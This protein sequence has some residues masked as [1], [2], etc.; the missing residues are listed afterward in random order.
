MTDGQAW[1]TIK[2]NLKMACNKTVD[3]SKETEEERERTIYF[4]EEILAEV[5]QQKVAEPDIQ[6]AIDYSGI[7][8]EPAQAEV[9]FPGTSD[10]NTEL[11]SRRIKTWRILSILSLSPNPYYPGSQATSGAGALSFRGNNASL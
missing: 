1:Q 11:I 3:G 4:G 6:E 10:T 2:P 5:H 9:I 7:M 8:E